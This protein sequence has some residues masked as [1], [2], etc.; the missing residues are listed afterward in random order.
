MF[1]FLSLKV[2]LYSEDFDEM[3]HYAAF[4]LGFHCLQSIWLDISR[5]KGLKF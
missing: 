2:V 4:H 3:Q 5:V 1:F